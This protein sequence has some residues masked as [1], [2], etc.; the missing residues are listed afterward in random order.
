MMRGA[1][2]PSRRNGR[3]GV[4]GMTVVHSAGHDA[5]SLWQSVVD[6]RGGL[7]HNDLEW[8]D[9][10]CWIGAVPDVDRTALPPEL[11]AW[12]S[13]IHRL[14]WLALQ[15][16]AFQA[17]VQRAV[18]RH[19]AHRIALVIGTTTSGMRSTEVAY[20]SRCRTGQWPSGFSY[21]HTHSI[22]APCRFAAEVLG[23]Q[24]PMAVI[25][26]ACSSSAK[27]FLTAQRWIDAGWADAAIVGGVDSLCLSTLHGFDSLQ[28]LSDEVC[29]PFDA[30]RKGISIGE[31]AAYMLLERSDSAIMFAGGGESSDA[32]HISTPHP[33]GRGAQGA[34]HGALDASGLRAA[35]I[36]YVNAHGTGTAANDRAESAALE[37]VFGA[38]GVPVSSTK[39]VTGHTLGAAGIVDAVITV[40]ALEKQMLPRSANLVAA[41][42][43]LAVDVLHASRPYPLRHAMSNSFGFGGSNCSLIFSQGH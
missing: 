43:G 24:G 22:D 12:E 5:A 15:D 37:A 30:M 23:I 4:T 1:Q 32:W 27:V 38:C 31:A 40:L 8:C 7:R 20:A 39:G 36:G 16:G 28:L 25:S 33:Q 29:R 19:G 26:T 9:L 17:A 13:R 41:D 6:G 18:V 14:A 2:E 21:R 35:D 3:L 11:A 10:P 34:M 42:P